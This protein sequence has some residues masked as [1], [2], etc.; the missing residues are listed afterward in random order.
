MSRQMNL[1]Y[2]PL[3]GLEIEADGSLTDERTGITL[4]RCERCGAMDYPDDNSY[5]LC[6][7]CL[8]AG[9]TPPA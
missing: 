9:F 4:E 7:D 5:G 3:A 6:S 2:N 8:A 1:D